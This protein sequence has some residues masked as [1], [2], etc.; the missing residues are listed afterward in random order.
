MKKSM[1]LSIILAVPIGTGIAAGLAYYGPGSREDH[2][3]NMEA[4]AAPAASPSLISCPVKGDT[5]ASQ[6]KAAG[7]SVYKGKTY[8]FCCPSCKPKFDKD[9]DRYIPK[10]PG[11][12]S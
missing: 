1:L 4:S 9:P 12:T 7:K 2:C 3:G 5:I 11:H 8:Y 10:L 6:E